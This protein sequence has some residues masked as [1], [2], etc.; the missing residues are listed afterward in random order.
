MVAGFCRLCNRDFA[1]RVERALSPDRRDDDRRRIFHAEQFDAHVDLADVDE[2]PRAQLEFQEAVAIGAQR[3]L[4]VDAGSHVTE[5]RRWDIDP[6]DRLEIE[7]VDRLLR[8]LD[9]VFGLER[10]PRDRVG[11]LY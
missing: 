3:Y 7:N 10:S 4:I 5:M 1:F 11:K 8:A 9:Q 6:A 2:S